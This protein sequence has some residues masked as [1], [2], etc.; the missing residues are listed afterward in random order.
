M[1]DGLAVTANSAHTGFFNALVFDKLV[2][3][4]ARQVTKGSIYLTIVRPADVFMT[5]E[6]SDLFT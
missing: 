6:L 1:V 4:T 5:G 2:N 3:E